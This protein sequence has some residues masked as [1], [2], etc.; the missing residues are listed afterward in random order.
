[1]LTGAQCNGVCECADGLTY[2][3]G[4]CRKL[5]NLNEPCRDEIDCFF[6]FNRESVECRDGKCQCADGFYQRFTNVCRRE[7]INGEPCIVNAD[8]IETDSQCSNNICSA[9]TQTSSLKNAAVQTTQSLES[10]NNGQVGKS[11]SFYNRRNYIAYNKLEN[12]DVTKFSS[13]DDESTQYGESCEFEHKPCN[14]LRYSICR[15]GFC[16]CQ[17]GFYAK[18]GICKAELGELVEDEAFCG[19]GKLVKN[20]CTC[21]PDAPPSAIN[22]HFYNPNMRICT[23]AAI[24]IN[25]SCTQP[26]QCTP[27]GAAFCP[28]QQPRQC[29]CHEYAKY[30]EK[31]QMCEMK[32][33]LG[34][35]C[36]TTTNC[37]VENTVCTPSKTCEC[38][39]NF[40]AQNDIECKPGFG[41]E[42]D[43]TVDCAFENAECKIEIENEAT[44]TKKCLCKEDFVAVGNVCFEKAKS[45]NDTCTEND[46]CKPLL[47]EKASCNDNRCSCSESLHFKNGQCN[48]KKE[49][50]ERC[51]KSGEC[52]VEEDEAEAV[53]C[54]NGICQ[55]KFEYT[56][57]VNQNRCIRPREKN[58][59]KRTSP[60]KVVT[61]MLIASAVVVTGS[62]LKDAYYP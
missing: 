40:I 8:C 27:Y 24:G 6:G 9:A 32:E 17:D 61:L 13:L 42:C 46:Q 30:N 16:Q 56:T 37:K 34:E 1:M 12:G 39:P 19:S 60:L 55:C 43:T 14:G 58:S 25:T 51:G 44:T 59:S 47:G 50:N 18:D 49:L 41:A 53:E 31:T 20:R 3:R 28:T 29:R 54:R 11:S 33:G 26:S 15:R 45:Y 62:A 7:S 10:L 2:V 57:D 4:K 23:K 36:E 38:K 52:F 21:V 5:V 35:F 22:N 48:D